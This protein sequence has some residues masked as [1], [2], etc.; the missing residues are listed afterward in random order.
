M[1]LR[2]EPASSYLATSSVSSGSTMGML[3]VLCL[4]FF[5]STPCLR[6]MFVRSWNQGWNDTTYFVLL[7]FSYFLSNTFRTAARFASVEIPVARTISLLFSVV[8]STRV[9]SSF[10]LLSVQVRS[11]GMRS[12]RENTSPSFFEIEEDTGTSFFFLGG[13]E[14]CT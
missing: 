4:F 2:T 6:K 1:R 8:A 7:S 9:F 3:L 14:C 12:V 10:V 11:M 13:R 5:P